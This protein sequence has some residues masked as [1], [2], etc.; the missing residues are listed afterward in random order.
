MEDLWARLGAIPG[1]KTLAVQEQVRKVAYDGPPVPCRGAVLIGMTEFD[2]PDVENLAMGYRDVQL[3]AERFRALACDYVTVLTSAQKERRRKPRLENIV[4]AIRAMREKIGA[5]GVLLVF[6]STHGIIRGGD[7]NLLA[8]DY[9]PETHEGAIT[10][11][12]LGE[13]IAPA[14][15]AWG[16]QR[17]CLIVDYSNHYLATLKSF[18]NEPVEFTLPPARVGFCLMCSPPRVPSSFT[19]KFA[20]MLDELLAR[21]LPICGNAIYAIFCKHTEEWYGTPKKMMVLVRDR[22]P[23][24]D[25]GK[26]P[27]FDWDTVRDLDT[28]A[29]GYVLKA[30]EPVPAHP[31]TPLPTPATVCTNVA[32]AVPALR[33]KEAPREEVNRMF[34]IKISGGPASKGP[35]GD[36]AHYAKEVAGVC[37]E[38]GLPHVEVI[39]AWFG[40]LTCVTTDVHLDAVCRAFQQM[41]ALRSHG[42]AEPAATIEYVGVLIPVEVVSPFSTHITLE[43]VSRR[44]PAE[45]EPHSGC[46]IEEVG[47]ID[48]QGGLAGRADNPASASWTGAPP[49][50]QNPASASFHAASASAVQTPSSAAGLEEVARHPS[51]NQPPRSAAASSAASH[52][53]PA[54]Q[55][56]Q[57]PPA[58]GFPSQQQP[59]ST[60]APSVDAAA[61]LN[62]PQVQA[63]V[64]Q[65]FG[66]AGPPQSLPSMAA[67]AQ[68]SL[69]GQGQAP[70]L[71]SAAPAP[72]QGMVPEEVFRAE[73]QRLQA[74]VETERRERETA[75]DRLAKQ[76]DRLQQQQQ[77]QQ[78]ALGVQQQQVAALANAPPAAATA[79]AV[80]AAW[81]EVD[82]AGLKRE[83]AQLA[84]QQQQLMAN[85]VNPPASPPRG[86][87]TRGGAVIHVGNDEWMEYQDQLKLFEVQLKRLH[88]ALPGAVAAAHDD[89]PAPL[90]EVSVNLPG[91]LRTASFDHSRMSVGSRGGKSFQA[92]S[93]PPPIPPPELE[94]RVEALERQQV[95]QE[96]IVKR[97][98]RNVAEVRQLQQ[99][100][101]LQAQARGPSPS[102][103]HQD[104][105][106]SVQSLSRA[107][108]IAQ[109]LTP[110]RVPAPPASPAH[111]GA[112]EEIR[113]LKLRVERMER[114]GE[115]A[116]Q[117][118]SHAASQ[119]QQQQQQQQHLVEIDRRLEQLHAQV[120]HLQ[121]DGPQGAR[122]DADV[123]RAYNEM[124]LDDID[125]QLQGRGPVQAADVQLPS[126]LRAAIHQAVRQMISGLKE[127]LEAWTGQQVGLA[128]EDARAAQERMTKLE[129]AAQLAESC[130]GADATRQDRQ[131]GAN[132]AAIGGVEQSIQSLQSTLQAHGSRL[133]GLEERTEGA[134]GDLQN[135]Q[136]EV[137]N[138]VDSTIQ[139]IGQAIMELDQKVMKDVTEASARVA[140]A[141]QRVAHLDTRLGEDAERMHRMETR[142]EQCTRVLQ[143]R[144]EEQ[145]QQQFAS[146]RRM[147]AAYDEKLGV[148]KQIAD[149]AE[150]SSAELDKKW[151]D[152][153]QHLKTQLRAALQQHIEGLESVLQEMKGDIKGV[154]DRTAAM[155]QV[156][157][158]T[159]SGSGVLDQ[160]V[161][162]M[163]KTL[164][165]LRNGFETYVHDGTV[166]IMQA[167][168]DKMDELRQKLGMELDSFDMRV[169]GIE[170][171][172]VA[173]DE[174][175]AS[176]L[177]KI[178]AA[179][180]QQ[181]SSDKVDKALA[182]LEEQRIRPAMEAAS[183]GFEVAREMQ[184]VLQKVD[185]MTA[186][187]QQRAM[188]V[189]ML[190]D[191][192]AGLR[193]KLASGNF[194]APP[195]AAPPAGPPPDLTRYA[196][197]ERVDGLARDI[198]A[199]QQEINSLKM[200]VTNI[201]NAP[202]AAPQGGGGA[203]TSELFAT[204][205]N[206]RAE[207]AALRSKVSTMGAGDTDDLMAADISKLKKDISDLKKEVEKLKGWKNGK[208]AESAVLEKTATGVREL[209]KAV[210]DM[211]FQIDDLKG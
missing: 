40:K 1:P 117:S 12:A 28:S 185:Q 76:L 9:N 63:F 53:A 17:G 150:K 74:A 106:A 174:E 166:H 171:Q 96:Q 184:G 152:N 123:R 142:Q 45:R 7:L 124:M 23:T 30:S 113:A 102:A 16:G 8:T 71:P 67:S 211:K 99:Q 72:P 173:A 135:G 41:R 136:A 154:D 73:V 50:L 133:E 82:P 42:T 183:K 37:E 140:V 158:D 179:V 114:L 92:D 193:E 36:K 191:Q 156:V 204:I 79:P 178:Q 62:S 47:Q 87:P 93:I 130:R 146:E 38:R 49:H 33:V 205:E 200:Q 134:M 181:P 54:A 207:V 46:F 145:T 195:A 143:D 26:L 5:Q 203:D 162:A 84:K 91:A 25:S 51:W 11:D 90:Q 52:P 209:K 147:L 196:T 165:A 39:K 66:S 208:E 188:E 64:P 27:L 59:R 14:G 34:I 149:L 15:S 132:T 4:A 153:E 32:R 21:K 163:E 187:E 98:E 43:E 18:P 116:N 129:H 101:A 164:E 97:C 137:R 126:G 119:H 107:P 77:Q 80:P 20:S 190:K 144:V 85:Y 120:A 202:A 75:V 31:S 95:L 141:E 198:T 176:A 186:A 180:A 128:R 88:A 78:A 83:V 151:H 44:H 35:R 131:V 157:G 55:R 148:M 24:A 115:A 57:T 160:K 105:H 2:S 177:E 68:A 112:V 110:T 58:A 167:Q 138:R 19:A 6:V 206:V 111:G 60:A 210:D 10:L 194:G 127:Q 65:P 104:P 155:E 61:S 3:L 13:L 172:R 108:L 100:L 121:H 81:G 109:Q 169:R 118:P 175:L 103:T 168:N 197:N 161:Q 56:P 201:Q 70:P 189:G 89:V 22:A 86:S 48:V 125:N 139:R 69:P 192:V 29:V 182:A 122:G 159:K 199:L 94:P 170:T